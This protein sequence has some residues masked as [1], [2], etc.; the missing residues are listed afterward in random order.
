MIPFSL[1]VEGWREVN[2]S[3]ALVNQYQLLQL[4]KYPTITLYHDDLPMYSHWVRRSGFSAQQQSQICSVPPSLGQRTDAA[5]R[6]SYPHRLYGTDARR[7][8]VFISTEYNKYEPQAFYSGPEV[9]AR[10]PTDSYTVVTPSNWSKRSLIDM[11]F[12][13]RSIAVV[14][15]GVD[16][17]L[18][19]P[20]DL[21]ERSRFRQ[22]LGISP[23]DFLFLNVSGMTF[24]K[25]LDVL[26]TAFCTLRQ[27]YS[28]ASLLLKDESFLYG[29]AADAW[30]RHAAAK[31]PRSVATGEAL[32]AIYFVS[33]NLNQVE[34]RSLF[35]SAD[36]YVAPYRAEGFNLP[37]LEAAACGTP[38]IM[39][40]GGST[41]DYFHSSF[42]LRVESKRL[43][44]EQVGEFLEPNM[45]HLLASMEALIL[46]R[47]RFDLEEG[48]RWIGEH[49]SWQ[50]A[51]KRLVDLIAGAI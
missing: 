43:W 50:L 36:A 42:A 8:F 24:N 38:S 37:P 1:R 27:R 33:K 12:E 4:K 20:I 28:N 32:G 3:Y 49:F 7:L 5:Y 41:D 13:D 30:L 46:Q 14:P 16:T 10:Y 51:T 44:S 26:L 25:G 47:V 23:D 45:E 2:Q 19:Q 22:T 21:D 35:G 6:I 31:L 9:E 17:E 34:L 15:H 48:R 18:F 11:G 40:S 29:T 39:T